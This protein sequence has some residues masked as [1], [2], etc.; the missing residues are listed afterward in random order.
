MARIRH[1]PFISH[2]QGSPTEH[3]VH[4]RGGKQVH[5]GVGLGFWFRP[6][7]TAI[8][9]VPAIDHERA[10]LFHVATRDQQDVTVQAVLTYRFADP[11]A[12]SR[13]LDLAIFPFQ[14][15]GLSEQPLRQGLRQVA[16][17]LG[18]LAQSLAVDVLR[19]LDLA[20]ALE[21]GLPRVR[22]A[23][24]EGFAGH[25]RLADL[26]VQVSDVRVLALRPEEDIEKALQTPLREELQTEA[27]R[28]LYQRRALAVEREQQISENELS[29]KLELARRREALVAQEGANNRREAEEKAAAALVDA[30]GRAERLRL[31]A[32]ARAQEIEQVGQAQAQ[33]ERVRTE[34][35]AAL[36]AEVLRALALREAAKHLPDIGQLNFTPDLLTKLLSG[37]FGDGTTD[38]GSPAATRGTA[39]GAA[40]GAR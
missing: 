17:L 28:A 12:A 8:S 30:N 32:A 6:A 25:A 21:D 36:G 16:D 27:D 9:E 22:T 38:A 7:V 26:G 24:V 39:A 34:A 3:V 29:S 14:Q 35:Y 33:A 4:L 40:G 31:D 13:R 18:Q 2:Y 5:S 19:S 20:Q 15:V 10:V 1:Y 37:L 23:L 11:E